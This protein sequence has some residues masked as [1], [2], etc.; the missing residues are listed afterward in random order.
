M[1][2]LGVA[3]EDK[4]GIEGV[5]KGKGEVIPVEGDNS[6]PVASKQGVEGSTGPGQMV[7]AEEG[8][9]V[10]AEML[11]GMERQRGMAI[12]RRE[13]NPLG[14]MRTFFYLPNWN[15]KLFKLI[16]NIFSR[17]KFFFGFRRLNGYLSEPADAVILSISRN[18]EDWDVFLKSD[19]LQPSNPKN[20]LHLVL[21]LLAQKIIA[22][23]GAIMMEQKVEVCVA[24]VTCSQLRTAILDQ[25]SQYFMDSNSRSQVSKMQ[26]RYV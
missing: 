17:R 13:P 21:Q 16:C 14:G 22:D 26:A 1:P 8:A 23:S 15:R 25:C 3:V 2:T 11:R 9:E 20:N 12:I 4:G 19:A 18:K 6:I 7:E 5:D 24:A 10:L